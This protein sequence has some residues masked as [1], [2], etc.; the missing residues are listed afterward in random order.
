MLATSRVVKERSA[1]SKARVRRK[2]PGLFVLPR[3]RNRRYAH[4]SETC[5]S[6]FE[7]RVGYQICRAGIATG[8]TRTFFE[9]SGCGKTRAGMAQRE[10]RGVASAEAWVRGP[11]SA[12]MFPSSKGQD[13]GPS[14]R[15]C[16]FKSGRECQGD[17]AQRQSLRLASGQY[18]FE[19]HR[20]HQYL[21][22][23]KQE[24]VS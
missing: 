12:P 22:A 8:A 24:N 21:N 13:S 15:R 11:L 23:T 20:P 9:N 19:P 7:S 14:L 3:W 17:V 5:S 1:F 2:A 6:G 18:G 4:V 10:E 16:R